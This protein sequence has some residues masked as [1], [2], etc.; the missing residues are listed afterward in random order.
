MSKVTWFVGTIP[1]DGFSENCNCRKFF[2]VVQT[3]APNFLLLLNLERPRGGGG[4]LDPPG[5][6]D[7]KIENLKQSKRNFSACGPIMDTSFNVNLMMSPLIICA[8]L[9]MQIIV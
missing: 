9:I 3:K 4:L 7:L 5:F 8:K 2:P 1:A 6:S